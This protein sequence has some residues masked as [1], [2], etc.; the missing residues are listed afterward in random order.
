MYRVSIELYKHSG[1]LGERE[2]LWEHELFPQLFRVLP[3]FHECLYN[4]IEI[5]STCFLFF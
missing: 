4:S 5:Q 2:M 1:S 3:N